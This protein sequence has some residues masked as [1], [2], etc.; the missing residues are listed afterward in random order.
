MSAPTT[1]MILAAG[2]G[3][4]MGALT[5]DRPKPLLPLDGKPMIE[6]GLTHA[7]RVG[8]RTAVINLHYRGDM[9]RAHLQDR[10]APELRFSEEQPEILETGGGVAQALPL[11]G[12]DPFYVMNSD[13]VW[14]GPNP[15][16]PLRE[17][18]DPARMDTLLLLVPIEQTRAY[19]RPG[20][21]FLDAEGGAP[22]RRGSAPRAPLVYTGALITRP[23]AFAET[24]TGPFSLNV[25]WDRQLAEGRL[26]AVTYAGEWVDVGTPVGLDTASALLSAKAL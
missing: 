3:T 25:L 14:A 10:T 5:R 21:F 18:W 12:A 1:A 24:P 9:L 20:D 13:A 8:V 26:A 23:E 2:F 16:D 19:M 17:A 22:V 11:L 15:L 7:A 6:H 4:R